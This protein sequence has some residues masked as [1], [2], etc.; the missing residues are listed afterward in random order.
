MERFKLEINV[1]PED[2]PGLDDHHKRDCSDAVNKAINGTF[3]YTLIFAAATV[4]YYVLYIFVGFL[5]LLRMETLL[6]QMSALVPLAAV[7][8]FIFEF[9]AGTMR[10]WTLA[11]EILLLGFLTIA[12]LTVP[13]SVVLVPFALYGIICHIK[14][15][16]LV[17]FYI[18]LVSLPGYPDFTPLPIGDVISKKST[19]NSET[20]IEETK[21]SIG[22]SEAVIEETKK[23]EKSERNETEMKE[24]EGN[25]GN[26]IR[27]SEE[28]TVLPNKTDDREMNVQKGNDAGKKK[29]NKK[30]S[31]K[32]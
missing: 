3:K 27:K 15:I 23:E 6:P 12:A 7:A 4:V 11:V 8:V 9:A 32:A 24:K 20:V 30:R 2:I 28:M 25:K 16:A 5:W 13:P 19:G 22:N 1:R 18:V 10:K 17:P 31:K 21:K 26:E 14:L 29:R